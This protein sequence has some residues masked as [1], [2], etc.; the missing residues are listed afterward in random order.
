MDGPLPSGTLTLMFTDI[1]GSSRL[2]DSHR[3]T[4]ADRANLAEVMAWSLEHNRVEDM[5]DFVCDIWVYWFNGDLAS[6]AVQWA[7]DRSSS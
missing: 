7:G 2:W 6:K 5:V 3:A 4:A 1:E